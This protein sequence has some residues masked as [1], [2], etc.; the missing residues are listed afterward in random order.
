MG[1]HKSQYRTLFQSIMVFSEV[2]PRPLFCSKSAAK[3][4]SQVAISTSAAASAFRICNAKKAILR[5]ACVNFS[6]NSRRSQRLI[7]L[8]LNN[9]AS[10]R[11]AI[12]GDAK[13][14]RAFSSGRSSTR[15]TPIRARHWELD[16]DG[17]P[18]NRIIETRRRSELI[19]PVPKPQ[20]RR[21]APGQAELGLGA[22]DGLSTTEQEYNPTPIINEIRGYVENWRNLPNPE[23]VAGDA[24][25]RPA[26]PA[27]AAS[28]ISRTFARS[29]ARSRRSRPRSG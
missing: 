7:Y 3:L 28:S 19:T 11:R 8:R 1:G 10:R 2:R 29:S 12:T 16:Q 21:R 6:E 22:G 13:W 9:L 20:R 25:D 27:L 5:S 17:Q 14:S 26:A 23:P 4:R 24:G 15:P 18:T